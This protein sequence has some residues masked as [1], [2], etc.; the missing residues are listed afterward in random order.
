MSKDTE[1]SKQELL[2]PNID[3]TTQTCISEF[4]TFIPEQAVNN[5]ERNTCTLLKTRGWISIML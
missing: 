3:N 5:D 2:V 1:S 4:A